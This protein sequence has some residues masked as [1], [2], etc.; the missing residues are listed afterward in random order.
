MNNK[1]IN[2]LKL[3]LPLQLPGMALFL[4]FAFVQQSSAQ[5]TKSL[6]I[7]E[8][9][10]LGIE[11]SKVLKL[12]QAR[13][14][15]AVSRY[16]QAKDNILPKATASYSYNHAEIPTTTFQLGPGAPMHLP[17]R[18]D[19]F[20]GTLSVQELIFAGNKLK[21]A[22]ESTDLLARVARL[23]ADRDREEIVYTIVNAYY[24]LYKIDQSKLVVQYNIEAIDK[25]VTQAQ[26]FFDQGIVTKNDV[27][28]F[29]LLRSNSELALI[30]LENNRKVVNY[31]MDVL[32]GLPETTEIRIGEFAGSSQSTGPVSS[33][34]DSALNNR[35]EIKSYELRTQLAVNNINNIK[36]GVKPTVG[37]GANLYYI[38]PS[39][40]FIPPANRFIAP[41]SIGATIG[42]NIDRFWMNKN[43]LAEAS[44]QQREAELG[45]SIST[46]AVKTEVNQN[47]QNYLTALQ[48]IK[49]YETSIAQAAENDKILESKYRNNVATV[50]DRID[51]QT[52]LFQTQIN[53]EIAK[54]DAGLAYY[55]LLKSTGSI[56]PVK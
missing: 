29:Q 12:S 54:A 22:K 8:A 1:L 17:A 9:I 5:Q 20:I 13:V 43:R 19:A 21:F 48:R 32:L 56:T 49:V 41:F 42:W 2:F 40:K 39:G 7:T 11:N 3:R 18:A 26:R 55:S 16:N 38:N 31:N 34:I 36:A 10:S 53:L 50:T 52:Q 27:L 6:S 30:D 46:D 25:Q 47:Y 35:Q 15:E 23:D 45:R 14:D 44:I 24:N 33:Y 37:L 28:R 4:V 51:A